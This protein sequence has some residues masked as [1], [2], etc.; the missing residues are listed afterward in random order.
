MTAA[1]AVHFYAGA[2]Y[3]IEHIIETDAF[4]TTASILWTV[5]ALLL[6]GFGT[7]RSLRPVWIMGAALLALV[8]VKLFTIDLSNL[9][10]VARIVSF[11]TVGILMLIIGYFA[12]IPP[13]REEGPTEEATA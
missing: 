13:A 8:I 3:P 12:P 11:I 1:R 4:Q 10:I 7:R 9:E 6:M 2:A 5:T